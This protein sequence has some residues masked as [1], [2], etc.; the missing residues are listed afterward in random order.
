[1][2]IDVTKNVGFLT[3]YKKNWTIFSL[4]KFSFH[5][6]QWMPHKNYEK[7]FSFHLKNSFLKYLNFWPDFFDHVG[8]RLDK[9]TKFN[10]KTYDVYTAKQIITKHIML[11]VSRSKDNQT[12]KFGQS[13][14]YNKRN[15]F[16]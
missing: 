7:Y 2:K 13:F 14:E 8:K 9:K 15:I 12:I 3:H 1:M 4:P 6:L 10:L 16:L 11:N 5:L